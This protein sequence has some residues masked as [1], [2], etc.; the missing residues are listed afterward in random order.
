MLGQTLLSAGLE[1]NC[2]GNE[3]E[4]AD[5]DKDEDEDEDW[6]RLEYD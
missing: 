1:I 4:D 2:S 5:G 6:N 3:D